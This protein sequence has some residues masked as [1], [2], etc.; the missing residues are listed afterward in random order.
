MFCRRILYTKFPCWGVCQLCHY[1]WGIQN[2]PTQGNTDKSVYEYHICLQKGC[3]PFI[4][5]CVVWLVNKHTCMPISNALIIRDL[6]TSSTSPKK[7]NSWSFSFL[8]TPAP[9]QKE[10]KCVL[11]CLWNMSKSKT[12]ASE[13]CPTLG[14]ISFFLTLNL[15]NDPFGIFL[16]ASHFPL[17]WYPRKENHEK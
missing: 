14:Q 15:L 12:W 11:Q 5:Y 17:L 6:S 13:P 1:A 7:G 4:V 8:D 2:R 16:F 10:T 3:H 9:P